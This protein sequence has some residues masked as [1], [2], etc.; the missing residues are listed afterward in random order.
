MAE[1]SS[2]ISSPKAVRTL[3]SISQA[4]RHIILCVGG[5]C[6]E[7]TA[8]QASWN[9]LKAR[10]AF[11]QSA[12]GGGHVFLRTSARCLQICERG[13]IAVVYPEGIWYHS[14][15]EAVLDRIIA[16]H[17]I[18][19]VPVAE[20]QLGTSGFAQCSTKGGGCD[21]GKTE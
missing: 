14:C 16:E 2:T 10:V 5:A 12:E 21:G 1:I 17:L 9:Y 4:E 18:G 13:P 6:A 20:Y 7:Q 8:T 3:E 11:L 15:S 19:G